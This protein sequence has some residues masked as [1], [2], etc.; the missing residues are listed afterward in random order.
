MKNNCSEVNHSLKNKR[1]IRKPPLTGIEPFIIILAI[2]FYY[3][4]LLFL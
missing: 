3:V 2:F 4:E 1:L